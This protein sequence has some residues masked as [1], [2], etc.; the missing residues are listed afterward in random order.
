MNKIMNDVDGR[1]AI[2]AKFM[3][4][5]KYNSILNRLEDIR[6]DPGQKL[7]QQDHNW[8]RSFQILKVDLNNKI[9]SV[10]VKPGTHLR[11]YHVNDQNS[12]KICQAV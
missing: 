12:L 1:K 5:E 10:L 6:K 3:T 8:M 4:E 2:N 7:S 11:V 9:T